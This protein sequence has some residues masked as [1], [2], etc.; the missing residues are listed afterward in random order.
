MMKNPISQD[1][2][3]TMTREGFRR[4]KILATMGP[5]CEKEEILRSM[6]Q[7]GLN[8]VRCN[9]S[10]GKPEEHQARVELVRRL[11][12]EEGKIVGILG[13]LQG[14][15]IRVSR[16]KNKKIQLQEGATFTIDVDF[17]TEAGT[18]V[19]V[20][21]DY[22]ALAEDLK[23]SDVLLLDDGKIE[24]LVKEIKKGAVI[25]EVIQGGELSNNK[26]IN[27]QGGG[28]TAPAL[29]E[30][31]KEDIK[32]AAA[33]K[34]DYVAVSFVRHADDVNL[35]RELLKAA[36]S[37][38]HIIS[39]IERAEAINDQT[40][41]E[42]IL[43]SDG[44]MVA[45]GDLAVEIGDAEVP[46]IQKKI[47]RMALRCNRIVITATQMMESMIE[48]PVPTRAEISDVVNAVLDGTDAVMLSAETASG[49]FPIKV[50]EAMDR[51]CRAAEKFPEVSHSQ[52]GLDPICERVDQAIAMATMFTADHLNVQAILSLTESG[53][54]VMWMS[55]F[56]SAIP[57]I[58]L[59]RNIETMQRMSL[60]RGTLPLFFDM[61]RIPRDYINRACVE[62]LLKY[63][64]VQ[65]GDLVI[66]TAGDHMG[67]HGGT[68][69]MQVV[70]VGQVV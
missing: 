7:K 34:M 24:L 10:H 31:D 41:E 33:L 64:C 50:L 37:E 62:E 70:K 66:L 5:A 30:K 38:A 9:F 23:V 49:S 46:A 19:I 4:T 14:P 18:E 52:H 20:G 40:L 6:I 21:S 63:Q 44:V 42:I 48:S 32:T 35:A 45:R 39:K 67:V 29:T 17:D 59:T 13:D 12:R 26:G 8:A 22:K 53:R 54:T 69:K 2:E 27:K 58:A 16:F 65:E 15:K 3:K 55:R 11:A 25:C 60:V 57:I 36:G 43:A 56:R 47:I 68:N 28:L 1:V 51:A 61:T